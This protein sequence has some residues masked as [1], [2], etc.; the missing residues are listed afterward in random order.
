MKIFALGLVAMMALAGCV[1]E[2]EPVEA[3]ADI[4]AGKAL[5]EAH[6]AACHGVDGRGTAPG[7]PHLAAQAEE[8]LSEAL[9]NYREGSRMHAALRDLTSHM[10]DAELRN[11]AGFYA[12]LPP[13]ERP[14]GEPESSTLSPY[15]RGEA[16]AA[17]CVECHGE[18]GVSTT[19]GVP[20]LAGQ[21]PLYF[22]AATQ[23][24]LHGIRDMGTMESS[25]RALTGQ[26]IE[27][28]ALYFASQEPVQREAPEV[29]DPVAGEPLSA[30]CGGCH[31][32]EGH[33]RDAATPSLAGQDAV[34]LA[35][36]AK[37]YRGHV[38][39][40][41]VMFADRSDREIEDI[42][43][44][45]SVQTP[46]AAE[47]EPTTAEKLVANC[48]RCHG[49]GVD[50][51]ALVIPNINGQDE[52]YLLIALRAYRDDRRHSSM[53]HK[54]SLPYS[55]TMIEAVASVYSRRPASD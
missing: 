10:D 50:N 47:L 27:K 46:T 11:V 22:I 6:C 37:A 14:A 30:Q 36:A 51:P 1:Q 12:S 16:L 41:D 39:H 43:A 4:N 2:Q 53:M 40:H 25:L 52:A 23:A 18:K 42:A 45:Y 17:A 31:G 54:M 13:V 29:G 9:H 20:S 35:N 24:Y 19:P 15:E 55:N 5:A 21:Q 32:A 8:Y 7:I 49:P 3:A 28:M 33:S 34:Y 26:D 38:R 48:D 44:F